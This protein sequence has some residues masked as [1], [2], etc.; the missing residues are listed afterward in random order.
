MMSK[1]NS[2]RL[3]VLQLILA[4][5]FIGMARLTLDVYRQIQALGV[6]FSPASQMYWLL[7]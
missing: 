7:F 4:G 5:L 3:I 2:D 1:K 6:I